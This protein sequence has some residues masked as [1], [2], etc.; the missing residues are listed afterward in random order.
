MGM[1]VMSVAT[2]IGPPINGALLNAYGG[3]LQV[4][5]FSGVVMLFGGILVLA[6]KMISGKGILTKG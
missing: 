2:L 3:F 1:A 6:A 4:Q 5:I